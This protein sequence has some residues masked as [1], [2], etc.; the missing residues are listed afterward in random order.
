MNLRFEVLKLF[1]RFSGKQC[2]ALNPAY[3]NVTSLSGDFE[4]RVTMQCNLGYRLVGGT[5]SD[6][7]DSTECDSNAQWTKNI[8]CESKVSFIVSRNL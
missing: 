4:T 6:T 5:N 3:T 1:Y 2:P 7:V 8:N